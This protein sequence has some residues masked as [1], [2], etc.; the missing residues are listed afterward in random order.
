MFGFIAKRRPARAKQRTDSRLRELD[1]DLGILMPPPYDMSDADLQQGQQE[2]EDLLA[3]LQPDSLDAGSREVLFNFVNDWLDVALARLDGER[4]ERQAVGDVLVGLARTE[5]ARLKPAYDSDLTR[6]LHT[7]EAL[8][9]AFRDLTGKETKHLL[10][11]APVRF[12]H[13]QVG[14][15]LGAVE[16]EVPSTVAEVEDEDGRGGAPT[17]RDHAGGRK[18]G[19]DE[20]GAATVRFAGPPAGD[21]GGATPSTT[22]GNHGN[23]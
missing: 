2:V 5:V 3:K 13:R 12:D 15:T 20:G 19:T 4:D 23:R 18:G 6:C 22:N 10:D 21:T 17:E 14:S 16:E 9:A 11:S 1:G 7:R 8:E